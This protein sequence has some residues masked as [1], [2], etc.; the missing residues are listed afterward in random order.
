MSRITSSIG[1]ATGLNIEQTVSQL[2]AIQARPRDTLVNLNKKIDGQRTALTALTAQLVSLQ[3]TIKKFSSSSVFSQ[4]SISTSDDTLLDVIS[5]GEPPLGQ[6]TFTPLRRAQAQQ[7]QSSRFTTTTQPV[8]AGKFSFRF[9]GFVDPGADLSLL[10][11]GQGLGPGKLRITDRSGAVGDIDL[12]LARNIDDVLEAINNHASI[13][14]D[15]TVV[16]DRIRL[17]DTTGATLSNL[18][19][20]ELGGTAAASLGIAGIDIAANSA[21]GQDVLTLFD[22]LALKHLNDGRGVRFDGALGDLRITLQDGSRIN[23]DF[24]KLANNGTF[25]SGTT[26]AANGINAQLNFTAVDPGPDFDG[27]A[28]TFIDDATVTAG[29]ETVDYD[30][31]NK[32]LHFRIDEGSTTANQIIAALSRDPEASSDFTAALVAGGNGTG[33][34]SATDSATTAAPKAVAVTTGTSGTNA[35]LLFRAVDGGA[36]FDDVAIRFID[37]AG[38]TQGAETVTYDDT[39]P[40]NKEL[41][42]RIDLG[43][44][45]AANIVTALANDPTASQI[46]TAEHFGG[47]TGA[48]LISESD[49]AYTAGGALVG[50]SDAKN[51]VTLNEVLD[52][53]NSAAPGQLTAAYGANN[54]LVLT[55]TTVGAF[56]FQVEQLNGS[57]AAEDLGLDLT[58]AGGTITGRRLLAG[59]KTTLVDSFNGGAGF[60]LGLINLTDRSGAT[61]AVDLS[62]TST[63]DDII[64]AI[65]SAGLGI[66]AQINS[67]RNGLLITDTTGATTS[68]LIIANG[69]ATNSADQL[70]LSINA[71][72][73]TKNSG[74]LRLQVVNELTELSSLNGGLG[75]ATGTVRITDN[76]GKVGTF[77]IDGTTKTVGDVVEMV[78]QLGLKVQARIND[79][80]DGILLID[81][82]G[83]GTTFKVEEGNSTTARDL[84]LLAEKK[85]IQIN[86]VDTQVIDGTTTYEVDISAT[87]NLNDLATKVNELTGYVR[88]SVF[89]DGS[90]VRPY[91]FTLFNQ[92][93][94]RSGELLVDTSQTSFTLQESARAQDALLQI[95]APGS[96][97]VVA[98]SNTNEFDGILPDMTLVV[99][100]AADEAVTVSVDSSDGSLVEVV[101]DLI[102]A[103]N[104]LRDKITELT[105][106]DE[107]T[108][109]SAVL[110]GDG[111]VLLVQF[112][113]DAIVSRRTFGVGIFQSFESLGVTLGDDGSLSLDEQKLK[114]KFREN[115]ADVK[116]FFIKDEIGLVDRLDKLIDQLA[117]VGDSVLVGRAAVLTRKIE[118][119]QARIDQWNARL[120]RSR[121]RLLKT[122]IKNEE[123]IAKLQGSLSVISGLAPLPPLFSTNSTQE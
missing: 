46:F 35:K 70:G 28:I 7:F 109:Q 98:S 93:T 60:N 54:N 80:G 96:G 83:G 79:A 19:V 82:A 33:L 103:Y 20:E 39:N 34:I 102:D 64:T 66:Q 84:S 123:A 106:F 31:A 2:I 118:A 92:S 15:A 32:T 116:D 26:T 36:E 30:F 38:V 74:S 53:I 99:K 101:N 110:Q 120:E 3:L 42:F 41:V 100:G 47:S 76:Q 49:T 81:T 8:G 119:N 117:G 11:A 72:E 21:D 52:L 88:A 85:T 40:L 75:V 45:T 50:K 73:T 1:L 90:V 113:L 55:D 4:R 87:D 62:A 112:D 95:G 104:K 63:L 37:D 111:R 44:T 77:S 114:Q 58:A 43:N 5:T 16:N 12:S 59:L 9:G 25:A 65:N 17:T 122:F 67:A 105:R 24:N 91:R 56:Q 121:E 78:G 57:H 10:S 14:V 89:S 23:L 115:P 29:Q 48:G 108:Q 86:N 13:R 107:V 6:F 97:G 94:G 22:D 51:D 27:F 18:R 69:D 71:A 61:A 68:N